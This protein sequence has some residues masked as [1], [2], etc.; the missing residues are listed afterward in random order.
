MKKAFQIGVV[1]GMARVRRSVRDELMNDEQR[2][3]G[4]LALGIRQS[5]GN[6][7]QELIAKGTDGG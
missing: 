1:A 2:N 6:S 3:V 5:A 4:A 7:R